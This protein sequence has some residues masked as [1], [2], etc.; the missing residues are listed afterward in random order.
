MIFLR[1]ET[2]PVTGAIL[3]TTDAESEKLL[4]KMKD[5][6]TVAVTAKRARSP[7]HNRKFFA[8]LNNVFDNQDQFRSIDDLLDAVKLEVGHSELKERLNGERWREP[9]SISFYDMGQDEFNKFYDAAVDK[10]CAHFKMDRETLEQE[11]SEATTSGE[12]PESLASESGDEQDGDPA[13]STPDQAKPE[14][15]PGLP[16]EESGHGTPEKPA[17]A[18]HSDDVEP[19]GEET[20]SGTYANAAEMMDVIDVCQTATAI[21]NSVARMKIDDLFPPDKDEVLK[22]AEKRKAELAK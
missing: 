9:K 16:L 1:K 12:E 8:M 6:Q 13:G 22:H 7:R 20:S 19:S 10:L 2:L 21:E 18:A 3:I 5:G 17:E 11:F 14:D 4:G 15:A